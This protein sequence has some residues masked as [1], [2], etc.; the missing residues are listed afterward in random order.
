MA[1][2]HAAHSE[3]IFEE[4][5]RMTG[6]NGVTR[7]VEEE[8]VELRD[9]WL[10][11]VFVPLRSTEWLR[12]E[13]H[14]RTFVKGRGVRVTDSLGKTFI[15]GASGWQYGAVGQGRTEIGEA[16]LAQMDEVAVVAPEY[17][18]IPVMKLAAKI[19]ELTPG[20]LSRVA[21]CSTGSEAVETALKMAK[22]YHVRQGEPM[23]HRVI[24]RH[25]S[26]H[27]WTYGCMSVC[28]NR[29]LPIKEFEPLA[30]IGRFVHQPY[31]YRCELGLDYPSC[32]VRCAR[33]IETLIQFEG[34]ETVSAV[35]AEP[36]SHACYVAVPPAEYWP[37]VRSIC[38]KY[39]VLLIVDEVITGFGRTGK[40]FAI[41]H[42]DVVP[43]IMTVAK[44]LT[45]GYIPAA[46]TIATTSVSNAFI[47]GDETPFY[48]IAT[49]GG[50]PIAAAGAL[51][52]IAIIERENLVEN[53]AKMGRVLLDGLDSLREYP[54]VGDVRGLGLCA[55]IE[56]VAD[57]KSKAGFAPE[58]AV[59]DRIYEG[60]EEGG[61]LAREFG[62][63]ILLTPPLPISQGEVEEVVA[64]LD[65]VI[66][67]I[68]QEVS[69]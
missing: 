55:C 28:G 13:G 59:I 65:R 34:P 42:W 26:Y 20:D 3:M 60:I 35:L 16:M 15:D 64:I 57:K 69:R 41:S 29:G 45:S 33:D 30:P 49:W 17:C 12:K 62:S 68:A 38:D 56:L 8:A 5:T 39:G 37:I 67:T 7:T 66:A 21:F 19:A 10:E 11:H 51:A 25:G 63:N 22:Q 58:L 44:G 50:S 23:R 2:E 53:S 40:W 6:V 61:L 9:E 47:G 4:D 24:A 36:I 52:N 27:G 32:D 31:C 54:I 1:P 48:Q 14:Y 43:D 46:G 18:A